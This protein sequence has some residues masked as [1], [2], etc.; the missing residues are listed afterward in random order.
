MWLATHLFIIVIILL[1]S[2]ESVKPWS[3]KTGCVMPSMHEVTTG[4]FTFTE[5]K[6]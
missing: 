5:V 3:L 1:A 6:I 4:M 2:G